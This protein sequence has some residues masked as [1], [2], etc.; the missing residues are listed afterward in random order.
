MALHWRTVS[1]NGAPTFVKQ[2]HYGRAASRATVRVHASFLNPH[3]ILGVSPAADVKEVK[4][5]YR[6]LAL[7]F[8]PD[9]CK[10]EEGHE[11]FITLTQAYE[12][13]LGRAEGK[14]DP[15]HA[16]ASGWDFHD[17]YWNFRMQRSW[18]KQ[19]RQAKAAA[20]AAAAAA[21]ANGGE[22]PEG[23]ACGAGRPPP[24]HGHAGFKQ[25]EARENLRSQLAGLRHRAAVR[26]N[27]PAAA[28]TPPPS[29]TA[30]ASGSW[31][32]A[33]GNSIDAEEGGSWT[34]GAAAAAAAT[35]AG[36]QG[37]GPIPSWSWSWSWDETLESE[38]EQSD[39]G[40]CADGAADLH[41]QY[42][43]MYDTAAGASHAAGGPTEGGPYMAVHDGHLGTVVANHAVP[44]P[45]GGGISSI[46]KQQQQQ[47]QQQGQGQESQQQQQQQQ[48][49][50]QQEHWLQHEPEP[51]PF[52]NPYEKAPPGAQQQGF[53][54]RQ[55]RRFA[56]DGA[57]REAVSHQLA[58]LRRKAAIKTRGWGPSS[59]SE[60]EGDR[61]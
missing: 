24:P 32:A 61:V 48:P 39:A 45:A 54:A 60:G 37:A 15:N 18:E 11:R 36:G 59:S 55:Q 8:H 12:M 7:Q 23:F 49:E 16:A 27:R 14:T 40:V 29:S 57:T 5:A 43:H 19:Q 28:A 3:S 30:C 33:S 56:A 22:P 17:W 9:V 47:Q 53:S 31:S 13:L 4:R 34:S 25:P 26:A 41:H 38:D 51:E 44:F 21:D 20:A 46:G 2:P 52:S 58:G 50:Q 35:S 10:S 1:P 42:T 6:K